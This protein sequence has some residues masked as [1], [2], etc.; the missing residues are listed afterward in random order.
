M[1]KNYDHD[2][3]IQKSFYGYRFRHS[4]LVDSKLIKRQI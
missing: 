3:C 1:L 2:Y 4:L